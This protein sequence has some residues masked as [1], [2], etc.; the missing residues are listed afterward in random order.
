MGG[1]LSFEHQGLPEGLPAK[2]REGG[3]SKMLPFQNFPRQPN[4]RKLAY[5]E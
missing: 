3:T 2:N 5:S 4:L 1:I